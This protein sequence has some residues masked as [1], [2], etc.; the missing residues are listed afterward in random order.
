VLTAKSPNSNTTTLTYASKGG[1]TSITDALTH[2]TSVTSHTVGGRPL[3]IVDPNSV[4]T[5]LTYDPRQRLLTSTVSTGAGPLTTTY[6]YDAAGNPT[7]TTLPDSSL[8][9]STYDTAH[10]VTRICKLLGPGQLYV[11]G[12]DQ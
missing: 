12:F 11:A 5:T 2:A 9:A 7:Q 10:R 8:V 1:L 4:T 6:T 3:T